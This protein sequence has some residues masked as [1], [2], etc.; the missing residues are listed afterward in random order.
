M[1]KHKGRVVPPQSGRA[2]SGVMASG[3]TAASRFGDRAVVR[4]ADGS[5]RTY[6]IADECNHLALLDF[7][8]DG[9]PDELVEHLIRCE[10]W[11]TDRCPVCWDSVGVGLVTTP[12]LLIITESRDDLVGTA[13]T[14][15]RDG[16][17]WV[18]RPDLE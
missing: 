6:P 2:V 17:S 8:G 4:F 18:L 16:S 15:M 11:D 13:Y 10:G 1:R 14:W 5:G 9:R 3:G 12:E 7:L